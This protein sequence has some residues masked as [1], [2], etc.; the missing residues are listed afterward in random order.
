MAGGGVDGW[1][2]FLLGFVARGWWHVAREEGEEEVSHG[3]TGARGG[4]KRWLVA[5]GTW[6]G[7]GD[8]VA[9]AT[10]NVERR[11]GRGRVV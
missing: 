6:H 9:R 1:G 7:E 11:H 2:V 4:E 3:D 10:C 8:S 5:R